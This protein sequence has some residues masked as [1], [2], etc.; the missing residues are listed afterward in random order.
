MPLEEELA[1]VFRQWQEVSERLVRSRETLEAW[2]D[3]R[4]AFAHRLGEA[5]IRP[6]LTR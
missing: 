2:Q 1:E 4:Y 3:H 6:L 5:L